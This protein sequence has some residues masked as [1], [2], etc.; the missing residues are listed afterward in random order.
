M[1]SDW[2]S[3]K[4]KPI[5]KNAAGRNKMRFRDPAFDAIAGCG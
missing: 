5:G 4:A 1:Y 3:D 2:E